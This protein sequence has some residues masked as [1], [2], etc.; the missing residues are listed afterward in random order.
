[1]ARTRAT[2]L[3][4]GPR[5]AQL[6]GLALRAGVDFYQVMFEENEDLFADY[7]PLHFKGGRCTKECGAGLQ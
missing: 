4:L 2:P 1:M 3:A 6:L 5:N 7:Q